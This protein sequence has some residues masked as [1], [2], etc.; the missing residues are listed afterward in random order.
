MTISVSQAIKIPTGRLNLIQM[1]YFGMVRDVVL[2][3]QVAAQ[4]LVF[5]DFIKHLFQA[6]TILKYKG[7]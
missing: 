6:L 5:H 4:L 1:I 3:R 2:K 7:L